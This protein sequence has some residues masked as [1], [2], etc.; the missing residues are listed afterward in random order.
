M[1]AL[2]LVSLPPVLN[3]PLYRAAE[4]RALLQLTALE[5]AEVGAL[6]LQLPRPLE[7]EMEAEMV[8]ATEVEMEVAV[9]VAM[10]VAMEVE[11]EVE[12]AVE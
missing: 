11:T 2:A 3:L 5:T 10:E 6:H 9:E 8:E 12:M 7:V 4:A 1:S